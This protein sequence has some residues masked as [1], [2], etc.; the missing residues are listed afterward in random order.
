MRPWPASRWVRVALPLGA[1][2]VPVLAFPAPSLWWLAY[3]ALVP[4]LLVLRNAPSGRAAA[5]AGWLGGT[6][7]ML[8]MHHWLMPNLH[9]F[10]LLL[11]A[12]LGLLWL[13]WG[14]LVH[15]LL[16]GTPGA[17][18]L[19]AAVVLVPSGWLLAELV[20]SWEYLGGPWGLLGASQWEVRP[21]LRLASVGGVWLV[22]FL[23]VAVNTLLAAVLTAPRARVAAVVGLVCVAVI[24]SAVWLWAPQPQ[25]AG[26]TRI[27]VVQIGE[28]LSRQER[29]ARGEELTRR[30][31]NRDPDLVVWGESSVGYDLNAHPALVRRLATLSRQTGAPLLVNV[32]SRRDDR[33]GIYKSSVLVDEHGLAGQRYDKMRLVPFGEY[34]PARAL[35]GWATSVG[36]AAD[37]DRKRGR[38]SVVMRADGLRFGPLICFETAFP[39]MSRQLVSK[40]ARVLVAQSSTSTFQQSWAPEQHASLAALRSAES[41]RPMVHSTLTGISAF[42]GPEGERVGAPMGTDTSSVQLIEVPLATGTTLYVR[43]GDWMLWLAPTALLAYGVVEGARAARRRRARERAE[44]SATVPEGR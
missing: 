31:A 4:W 14:W 42:Y 29:F 26:S 7:F 24:T 33:P 20:R 36:R 22:S 18:R 15:R 5:F 41:G 21:A 35:L 23:L 34:I 19:A 40:G 16:A 6:G 37:E 32:D 38:T 2:A 13:P 17:G 8:V 1:G 3:V 39:D 27:A 11:A 9:V 10:I 25:P 44:L 30:L 43:H 12:L 28:T